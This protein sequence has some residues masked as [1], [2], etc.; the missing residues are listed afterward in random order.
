MSTRTDLSRGVGGN[1]H[2]A[3]H[4]AATT[5]PARVALPTR[6]RKPWMIAVAVL[7][8]VGMA[9][10]GVVLVNRAAAKADVLV[11]KQR[12]PTGHVVVAADLG[13]VQLSGG[14]R[15]IAAS[16]VHTVVG[17]VAAVELVPGQVV[18]RDMLTAERV[19]AAGQSMIGL[20]L[21][22]GQLPGDGIA[23][24]DAVQL[25]AVPSKSDAESPLLDR[26]EVLGS[27]ATV[28]AARPD[29]TTGGNMLVTL[30]VPAAEAAQLATYGSAGK[31]ALIK[32]GG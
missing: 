25:V 9:L 3:G 12:V 28:Y 22:P 4:P 15:A 10:L 32:V 19:P 8:V 6:E 14:I 21:A 30:V 16:D 2:P 20:S 29:T 27:S 18:N 24:G 26:P 17:Q 13:S 31:V 5:A 11:V 1:G 23:A 7:L